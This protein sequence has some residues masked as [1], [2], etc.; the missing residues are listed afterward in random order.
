MKVTKATFDN[1]IVVN[2]NPQFPYLRDQPVT[3]LYTV[4][5]LFKTRLAKKEK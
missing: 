1:Y 2:G 5:G 4:P 3:Q